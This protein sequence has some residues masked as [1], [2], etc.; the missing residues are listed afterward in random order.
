MEWSTLTM[1]A[2][3]K[4][5]TLRLQPRLSRLHWQ[6]LLLQMLVPPTQSSCAALQTT[7]HIQAWASQHRM[8]LAATDTAAILREPS[9]TLLHTSGLNTIRAS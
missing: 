5:Q 3:S 6:P 9:T 7:W 2:C 1:M 4:S 8:C